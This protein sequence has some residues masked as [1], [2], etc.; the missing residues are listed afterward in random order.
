MVIPARQTEPNGKQKYGRL[1]L[2]ENRDTADR[3]RIQR[4]CRPRS[5]TQKDG[6]PAQLYTEA[7]TTERTIQ[8]SIADV[9]VECGFSF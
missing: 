2:T 8:E 7:L 9:W 5:G 4:Y 6:T 3:D 1:S